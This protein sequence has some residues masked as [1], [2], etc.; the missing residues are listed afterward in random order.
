MENWIVID[1][2][3]LRHVWR[4]VDCKNES[5]VEP[6]WYQNNGTPVCEDCDEDMLYLSTEQKD[7]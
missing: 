2:T 4:C 5:V 3:K 1:D 7:G 6:W